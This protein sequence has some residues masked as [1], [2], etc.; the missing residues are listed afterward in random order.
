MPDGIDVLRR[1]HLIVNVM[2]G[3]M[4]GMLATYTQG[5]PIFAAD[6]PIAVHF[7]M[8]YADR[9]HHTKEERALLPLMAEKSP[10]LQPLLDEVLEDHRK[11]RAILAL[12]DNSLDNG[13]R[14]EYFNAVTDYLTFIK[15]HV[16][17][18][19]EQLLPAT[20]EILTDDEQL[21]LANQL[22]GLQQEQMDPLELAEWEEY[23]RKLSQRYPR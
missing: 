21:F 5:Q 13:G 4:E 14:Q 16:I 9:L 6:L 7:F 17:L 19:D 22:A 10:A 18:E 2:V 3:V 15:A 12:M 11:G 20:D 23:T 1:E 8:R